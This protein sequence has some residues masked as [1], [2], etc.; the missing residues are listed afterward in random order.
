[1]AVTRE[2]V[3]SFI[4]NMTVLELSE[5]IKI[6]EEKFGVQA[7]MPMMAAGAGGRSGCGCSSRAG[8]GADG[9]QRHPHR[10]RGGQEDPGDQGREG[11]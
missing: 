5:F 1:M 9:V 11:R 3:I 8:G 2:E 6:L 7:A 10:I 4:E